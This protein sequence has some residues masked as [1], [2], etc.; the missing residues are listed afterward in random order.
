[1]KTALE[2]TGIATVPGSGFLQ[3]PGTHHLRITTL[4]LPEKKLESAMESLAKFNN[5]FHEKYAK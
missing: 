1:L 4:I 3:Y 2:E 5:K